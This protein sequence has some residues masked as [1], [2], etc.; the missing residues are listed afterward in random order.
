MAAIDAGGLSVAEGETESAGRPDEEPRTEGERRPRSRGGRDRQRRDRNLD[1][2]STAMASEERP[3]SRFGDS[4]DRRMSSSEV[5]RV[6]PG[7]RAVSIG[8]ENAE[9]PAEA[10]SLG[11][12]ALAATPD[13][14]A[15]GVAPQPVELPSPP[16]QAAPE[17][18]VLPLGTLE[19]LAESAGLQWVN[20]DAEKIRAAREAMAREPVPIHV[21]RE[22]KPVE[23]VD[24]GPLVLVE[25]RKDLSQI[26]LPFETAQQETQ[27][28]R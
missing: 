4:A 20:S 14:S 16:P 12:S 6:E 19:A 15:T 5:A 2:S 18:F 17:P 25:T 8:E 21:P 1:D 3:E 10:S 28:G 23:R 24:E 13:V 7:L 22:R 26:K 9:A 27:G 11:T